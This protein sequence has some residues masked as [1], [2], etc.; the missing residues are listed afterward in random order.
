MNAEHA[1]CD[2]P[3][4]ACPVRLVIFLSH[5]S[6][7]SECGTEHA[8]CDI[9]HCM[10]WVSNWACSVRERGLWYWDCSMWCLRPCAVSVLLSMLSMRLRLLHVTFE[11]LCSECPTE[12]AQYE[13]KIAPCDLPS[14]ALCMHSGSVVLSMLSTRDAVCGVPSYFTCILLIVATLSSSLR[15]LWAPLRGTNVKG[16]GKLLPGPGHLQLL[17]EIPF[18][19]VL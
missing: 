3:Y 9:Q 18:P 10:L 12:H 11:V 14:E 17:Y 7:C 2:L 19:R 6:L 5:Q 1:Q 4:W 13:I 16:F 8:Q 15:C